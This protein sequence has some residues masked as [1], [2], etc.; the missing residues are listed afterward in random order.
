[1]KIVAI[2]DTHMGHWE[3]KV[4]AGDI[5]IHAGDATY[6]GKLTELIDFNR[7]LGTL[8]FKHIIFVPGNHD[9]LFQ[10]NWA[11]AKDMVFNATC[12]KDGG[13]KY[14]GLNFW[15]SPYTLEFMDWAFMEPDDE[16]LRRHFREIPSKTDV[17]IT[18]QP[19]RHFGGVM[20][21]GQNVGS[22]SLTDFLPKDLKLH[23]FG[24]I[25][26]GYGKKKVGETLFVNVSVMDE[27]YELSNLP[28]E[29]EL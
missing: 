5:L 4:P 13:F 2:S 11:F 21:D 17:L 24:H 26:A 15:G 27:D 8:D 3:L 12:L 18:H 1:M 7:W 25:H 19:P 6:E 29:I 10:E 20:K 16:K 23:V 14:A 28:V 22:Q 9:F